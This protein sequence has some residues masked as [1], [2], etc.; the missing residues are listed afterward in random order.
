VSTVGLATGCYKFNVRGTGTNGSGQRV[1]HI[2]PITIY[3]ATS[4]SSGTY[5]E[6]IGFAVFQVTYLDS[7]SIRVK[8]VSGVAASADDNSLLRAERARL[9][10]W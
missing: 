9:M 2:Q 8:A 3:V 10:P 4:A 1:V 5:V 6:I 7:N